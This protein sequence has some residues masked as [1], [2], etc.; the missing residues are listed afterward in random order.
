[1]LMKK[2]I[3]A[4]FFILVFSFHG[5]G[6]DNSISLEDIWLKGTFRPN[7]LYGLNWMNDSRFYTAQKYDRENNVI[8]L[9]KY[10]IESREK[11]STIVKGMDLKDSEGK[12][13]MMEDYQF[14]KDE[15]KLLIGAGIEQVYRRSSIGYYFIFDLPSGKLIKISDQKLLNPSFSPDHNKVAYVKDNDL[16]YYD[17]L[18][19][20]EIRVT[21]DGKKNFI[22]NGA[23]DW[24]YEEEFE[25]TKAYFWSPDSK[26]LAFYRFDESEVKEY[27]MQLWNSLYPEDYKFKYP[28]AGEKNSVVAIKVYELSTGAIKILDIGKDIEQ[29][30]PRVEWT[31]NPAILCVRRMNR[32]QNHLEIMLFDVKN[33]GSRV[34]YEEKNSTYIEIK[35]DLVFLDNKENFVLSSEKDGFRH[36]YKG[37]LKSGKITQ[38]TKGK[39]EVTELAG[40]NES[41]GLLYFTSNEESVFEKH[42]YA[43]SLEGGKRKKLTAK[44]GYHEVELS[45]D[46]RFYL[47]YFSDFDSPYEISVF[48]LSD[49]K[50][51][52]NLVD[53]AGLENKLSEQNLKKPQI[54]DFKTKDGNTV[55]GWMILPPDF[56]HEKKYPVLVTVYGGPGYQTVLNQWGGSNYL[57]YQMLAQKG[58]VVVS[59]DNRGT[60]G[61]G[62]EFKKMTY[63]NLGK[64]E[65][66]D[67]IEAAK[68]LADLDY[69]DGGRIGIFGWSFGGY[70]SSLA[71][72]LG[73]DFYKLAIAVAPV[74]SWRF[75]DTIYTERYLGLPDENAEGYDEFSPLAHAAALKG[76]YLLIHGTADDNVHLQ[77]AM[78]MQK[79]LI[80]ANKQ[81]DVFYYPD[82]N[83]GIYGGVTRYHLFKKMTDFITEKL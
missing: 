76:D 6:Q 9:E 34:I 79:A 43:V 52:K 64:Y 80:E 31:K 70:M 28:K 61:R 57:W 45:P 37:N 55:N 29:Y 40:V 19:G 35:D 11:E 47:D 68:Y 42:L 33:G 65:S 10:S 8:D 25:F 49:G 39:F 26:Y 66:E 72:T 1:M 23:A 18:K 73:A 4:A 14:S 27:N 16:Y 71:I 17:I 3:F 59:I 5:I 48:D 21:N 15:S 36:F 30:I 44:T 56:D 60:G 20:K 81:F 13:V 50:L 82:R 83:H 62:A 75:Y 32:M 7:Y 41:K 54:F 63:G 2:S 24:V 69:I 22:I 46:Q 53:N 77:N 38:L 78:E 74:T 67:L 51:I 58:F 12:P